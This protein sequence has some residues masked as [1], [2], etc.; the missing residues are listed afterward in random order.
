M[1]EARGITTKMLII[2]TSHYVTKAQWLK[3]MRATVC[4]IKKHL[5]KRYTIIFTLRT[6]Q[7][8]DH[9]HKAMNLLIGCLT[10]LLF[11]TASG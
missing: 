7:P 2:I 5:N 8:Q 9:P 6:A 4:Y 1:L 3:S 10:V 11:S